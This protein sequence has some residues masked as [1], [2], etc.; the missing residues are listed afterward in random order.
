MLKS[1]WKKLGF[2][3]DKIY[4]NIDRFGNT[5]AASIGL[6]LHELR[7]QN[8]LE[9]G[10]FVIFVGQGGGLTWGVSLWRL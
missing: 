8:R 7:D 1:A 6:C 9:K 2:K 4:I 10:D 3:E 5:S